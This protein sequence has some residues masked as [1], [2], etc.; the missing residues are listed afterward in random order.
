[1]EGTEARR[2]RRR[3]VSAKTCGVEIGKEA[4]G[5]NGP[6]GRVRVID[7]LT[8]FEGGVGGVAT[9][10][11]GASTSDEATGDTSMEG[12]EG[13]AMDSLG[14]V[15]PR[16]IACPSS[17][18]GLWEDTVDDGVHT[19]EAVMDGRGRNLHVLTFRGLIS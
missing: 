15:S 1:M 14:S 6:N 4:D 11:G 8:C 9:H 12:D 10:V 18:R 2:F 17:E 5:G 7:R 16:D 13:D 19:G 3:S